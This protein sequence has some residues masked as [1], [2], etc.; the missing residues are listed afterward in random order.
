MSILFY[1]FTSGTRQS[2][3]EPQNL[4][5]MVREALKERKPIADKS[6]K[7][8]STKESEEK[9]TATNESDEDVKTRSKIWTESLMTGCWE[10]LRMNE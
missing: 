5:E 8:T 4:T 3:A 7:K 9:T 2:Y 1:F 6:E 10:E